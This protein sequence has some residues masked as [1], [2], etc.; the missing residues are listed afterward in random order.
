MP[1]KICAITP[2][3][4]QMRIQAAENKWKAWISQQARRA[5]TATPGRIPWTVTTESP[6]HPGHQL[7]DPHSAGRPT[8]LPPEDPPCETANAPPKPP[9]TGASRTQTSS[10][11]ADGTDASPAPNPDA[12]CPPHHVQSTAPSNNGSERDIRMASRPPPSTACISSTPSSCSPKASRGCPLPRSHT[13]SLVP[14]QLP[15]SYLRC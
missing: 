14:D 3:R 1:Y 4:H 7:P 15:C 9:R 5:S 11:T 8:R 2:T 6:G 13:R 10:R 12:S